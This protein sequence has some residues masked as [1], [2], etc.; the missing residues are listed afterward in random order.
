MSIDV[1]LPRVYDDKLNFLKEARPI[2]LSL[3][4]SIIPLSYASMQLP[5][6]ES[7]PA[8]G[9]VEIFTPMG[10]AGYFRVR[11][12]Q[13]AYG[14]DIVTSELEHAIV[15]VGDYLVLGSYNEMMSAK[16]AMQTIFSHYRG[17][18]WRL[19]NID[20]LGDGQVA[21]QTDHDRVLGAMIALLE[22]KPDCM[23]TFDFSTRPW[24]VNIVKRGTTVSAEGRLSRNVNSAKIA[25]DDTE[26]VT[27]CYYEY[28]VPASGNTEPTT[29]WDHIDT[30]T[31]SKYGLVER[32]APTTGSY[33]RAEAR[34]AAVAYAEKH[35]NPRVSVSIS[36][37]EL[38]SVTG[39]SFDTFTIGK[40]FRLALLDYNV[41]IERVVTGLSWDDLLDMPEDLTVA[42]EDEEDTTVTFLHDLDAKGGSGGGGGGKK[43]QEDTWKEFYTHFD[44]Q[45]HYIDMWAR[46]VDEANSILQQA[47]LYLDSDG[48][49]AYADDNVNMWAA[50]LKVESDRIGLVVSGTGENARI[51]PAQIVASIN[52]AGSSIKISADHVEIQGA[53][54]AYNGFINGISTNS[55]HSEGDIDAMDDVKG[56]TL[57]TTSGEI[58]VGST[59]VASWKSQSVVTEVTETRTQNHYWAITDGGGT[60]YGSLVVGASPTK[61]TIYYLGRS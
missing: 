14:D 48:V 17:N 61:K 3:T 11:S 10:S 37:E 54:E 30:N 44:K 24:K 39:E 51:R 57:T 56:Y 22:Q 16:T 15:E 26:L 34:A 33:T 1:R 19:G 43:K 18:K 12:P 35:K 4:L 42:L 23:F 28:S 47:G 8:R 45:D 25:Y 5:W 21:L 49:L 7:L 6:G 46:H 38:S 40:L 9:Y 32:T 60:W 31:L 29:A 52:S 27:R 13:E 53:L 36:A 2:K 20:A 58:N 41:T 50:K 59:Y 55:L